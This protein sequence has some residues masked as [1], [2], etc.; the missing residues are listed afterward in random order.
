MLSRRS[1][2]APQWATRMGFGRKG[3]ES[4]TLGKNAATYRV[5]FPDGTG[6]EKR[7]FKAMQPKALA[8]VYCHNDKW[9]V[10]AVHD[11]ADPRLAHYQTVEA[12]RVR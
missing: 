11:V 1:T 6:A 5:V 12:E 7:T 9:Y 4:P 10:A 3:G 2:I 8:Y